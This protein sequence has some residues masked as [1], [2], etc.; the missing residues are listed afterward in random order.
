[1]LIALAIRA[2]CYANSTHMLI[3]TV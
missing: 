1:M 2:A 3:G